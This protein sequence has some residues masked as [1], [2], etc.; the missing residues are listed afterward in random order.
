MGLL[1]SDMM[2]KHLRLLIT[3]LDKHILDSSF[4]YNLGLIKV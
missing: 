3:I 1:I 4:E 2:R